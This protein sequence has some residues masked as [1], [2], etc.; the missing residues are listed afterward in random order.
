MKISIKSLITITIG[1]T[2]TGAAT[3]LFY[4]P[5]KIV[6]GGVS[7]IATILYPFGI[8]PGLVYPA[9]NLILLLLSMKLGKKFVIFSA[10][11]VAMLS[12]AV[13][14]FSKMPSLTSNL[15]LASFFG[16]V[17]SGI[18]TAL[19]LI[20]GANTGGTDIVGRLIQ[21]N[22][23]YFPIGTL[24]L[25]IDGTIILISML[26]FK[27][28]DLALYGMLGLITS[29]VI[30]NY[31]IDRLNS[32]KLAF[33]ISENGERISKIILNNSHRG[34]TILNARGAYSGARK[35]LLI[36]ALKTS[37][38]KDFHQAIRS[39][40]KDAFIIF[41]KSDKIFGMGFYVYK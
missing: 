40:D 6:T 13:E 36:C 1:I 15:F 5:N 10:I 20:S 4:L 26:I 34:V 22:R 21:H 7:G 23:P 33:V 35:N 17:L 18:G 37:D 19:T 28:T 30:I 9:I 39:A 12:V 29:S 11:S 25:I 14:I 24:L 3:G 2:L 16:S 38:M 27:N 41:T 8:N 32:A 31:I